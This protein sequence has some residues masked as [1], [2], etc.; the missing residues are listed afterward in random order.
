M[1]SQGDKAPIYQ[2][3]EDHFRDHFEKFGQLSTLYNLSSKHKASFLLYLEFQESKRSEVTYG[4]SGDFPFLGK[5][6]F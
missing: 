4:T 3:I 5:L 6:D 2:V 1:V